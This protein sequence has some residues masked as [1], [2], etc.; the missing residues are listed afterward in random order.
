MAYVHY[1]G[2]EWGNDYSG[3]RK[4]R[5]EL[6]V[7]LLKNFSG[8]ELLLMLPWFGIHINLNHPHFNWDAHCE[9]VRDWFISFMWK[10]NKPIEDGGL[11]YKHAWYRYWW[12]RN[13][14]RE[15]ERQRARVS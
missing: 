1:P 11:I 12:R 10:M 7:K 14:E 6:S 4:R 2:W 8:F 15:M 9:F 13:C 5:W 3:F